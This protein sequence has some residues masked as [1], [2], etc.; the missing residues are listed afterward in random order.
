VDTVRG[1]TGEIFGR[2]IVGEDSGK[3][4]HNGGIIWKCKCDCGNYRLVR[5]DMLKSGD[6]KSCGCLKI[7]SAKKNILVIRKEHTE[8][9]SVE[10]TL[11][12]AIQESRKINKNNTSGAKGVY[13]NKQKKKWQARIGFKGKDTHIGYFL[14]KQDAINARLEAEDKYFKP[15]LD[16]Y[17]EQLL[18]GGLCETN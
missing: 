11:L 6:I 15:I 12:S 8:K 10:G 2:L 18:S 3:R 17:E 7:D 1:L 13:W 5:G 14:N 9:L 4:A 16:K